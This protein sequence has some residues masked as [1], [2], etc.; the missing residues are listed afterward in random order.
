MACCSP[1]HGPTGSNL[2]FIWVRG[3]GES[4]L[5]SAEVVH[6][7]LLVVGVDMW[8]HGYED[9]RLGVGRGGVSEDMDWL[10]KLPYCYLRRHRR[11]EMFR[12]G[13]G[14]IARCLPPRGGGDSVRE[15]RK[16]FGGIS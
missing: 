5:G 9:L 2:P 11:M 14:G 16:I 3:S 1:W 4:K 8:A 15:R 12:S 6:I 13:S 10:V 7:E